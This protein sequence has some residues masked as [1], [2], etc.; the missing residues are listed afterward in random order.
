MAAAVALLLSAV[1]LYGVI[2]YA[3]S[4][5]TREIGIRMALG[6]EPYRIRRT[7]LGQ[8]ASL[9]GQALIVGLLGAVAL[10]RFVA[11]LLYEVNPVDP[12]TYMMVV[13]V[14][15]PVAVLA[16]WLPARHATRVDPIT[17]LRTE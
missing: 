10:G 13:G 8:G 3:V 12:V 2:S 14:L 6:E 17:A 4:Q 9:V 16:C 5:R 11:S 15:G 1:G 7:I